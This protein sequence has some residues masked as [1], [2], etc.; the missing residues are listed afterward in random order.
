MIIDQVYT[1]VV[2]IECCFHKPILQDEIIVMV[3]FYL[4]YI[5]SIPV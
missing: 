3:H 1:L 2:L 5:E 4:L